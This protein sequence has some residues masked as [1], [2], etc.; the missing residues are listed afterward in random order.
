MR[1]TFRLALAAL[2]WSLLPALRTAD[3][4]SNL[5][6][7]ANGR[8]PALY[9]AD[10][11]LSFL[12]MR[13]QLTFT[14]E[15]LRA[16]TCEGSVEY[17]VQ[18]RVTKL[19]TVRLNAVAMRILTVE[20]PGQT[21]APKF[22]YDDHIL[23][24]SLP[25]PLGPKD[26]FKLLIKYSLADP[27]AGMHFILPSASAPHRPL[28][29]YTMGE[30]LEGRYWFPTH[31]WPNARW[32]S[33][34]LITVPRIYTAISN[35]VLR[36]R[37]PSAD[38]SAVTFHWHNDQP[39][40]PHLVGMVLGELVELRDSWHGKPVV[41]YTQPG[42]EA[43][44]RYTFRRVPEMLEFYTQLL[45]V[46][47]PYP[48]YTHITVVDHHHGGMEHAGFSFVS[49]QFIAASDNGDHPL[50]H[51]ESNYIS[52]MLAHMWFGG[53]VNYRS[54]SQ[55]WLN[56]GFAILLDRSW[57]SHTDAPPRFA[58]T[59]WERARQIAAF[60]TSERGKPLV[61]RNLRDPA[62][63][64]SDDGGKVYYKGGWVLHMLRHQLGEQVFWRGVAKYLTEHR[65]QAVETSDLRRA[66]EEVSGRDLEQFFEQW[67]Y[68]HGLP[69]LDV[70]YAW[71]A[72]RKR[73]RVTIRQTQKIDAATPA[74]AVPLDLYFRAGGQDQYRTVQLS[75]AR[76]EF[77]YDFATEPDIFCV[78]PQ[79][80]LL[81]TLALHRPRALLMEQARSGPTA[82]ARLMAVE[83][84]GSQAQPEVIAALGQIL[85]K[86]EEFWMVREA[87]ARGLGKMQM[88]EALQALLH[89]ERQPIAHPRVHAAVLSAL[90]DY[91][92][93]PEAHSA[94][95]RYA[96]AEGPLY[97]EL[98]AVT[99]LGRMRASPALAKT[100]IEELQTAVRKPSRRAVRRAALAAL[101]SLDDPRAYE[102]L[103]A[104]AAP[105]H[106]DELRDQAIR[107][108]GAL[109]R[110]ARLRDRTRTA[111]TAWLYDPDRSAQMAAVDALSALADPR[112]LAD[113]EQ[114]RASARPERLRKSAQEGI[115]AIAR[116]P[117]PRQVTR[118]LMQRLSALEKRNQELEKKLKDLSAKIEGLQEAQKK[119]TKDAGKGQSP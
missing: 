87:A 71:D 20:L 39:T 28:M 60:D 96:K 58:C 16:R 52:H 4:Q 75:E 74:F 3:A 104:L 105:G 86:E 27:P 14:P 17:T 91:I 95:L 119:A 101:A 111:L 42:Q 109:G 36:A 29:V 107:V 47:F 32:T 23:T 9:T 43:A 25:Q 98:A 31:D 110:H 89:A 13:L 6:P 35:G 5:E 64:Y 11:P 116:A 63:I 115:E 24:I 1:S 77:Q 102:T 93:S 53:L 72:A 54:V 57:T 78:D 83:E 33:D 69:R 50:E 85:P 34:I 10:Q 45:G 103:F 26:T 73:A 12:H 46:D 106:D 55:A 113:L 15:G 70:T 68:G 117:D 61:N 67:V 21:A 118:G 112:S 38:G 108:L 18:P 49:P 19:E 90:G 76:H 30:P 79:G 97:V 82:L 114:I 94:V 56:E 66:L 62:D 41:V 59:F 40:D 44:A 81:K 88:D 100:S 37:Q 92:V 80:G 51:T 8:D 48:G 65:W 84:L 22:S 2:L 7:S 99:A